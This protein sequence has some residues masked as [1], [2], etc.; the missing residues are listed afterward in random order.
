MRP[1]EWLFVLSATL[2]VT[3]IGFVVVGA[4]T[5]QRSD[6]NAASTTASLVPVAS[7]RQ[8]MTGIVAPG[9]EAVFRAV[10]TTVTQQGTEEKQPRTPEEWAAVADGAAALAEAG[11]LLMLDGRALDRQDWLAM[12]RA[13]IDAGSLALKAVAARDAR[14]LF[15]AGGEVY[16]SCDNCHRQYMR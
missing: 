5:A 2:F 8:I 10:S 7:V 4:R 16:V 9:A 3:G 6:T 11:N 13:M 1:V 14:A 12:S 15:D